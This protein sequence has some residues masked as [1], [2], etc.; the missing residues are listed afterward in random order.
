MTFRKEAALLL[1]YV[2][3]IY[4]CTYKGK[5]HLEETSYDTKKYVWS[6]AI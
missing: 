6:T 2:Y 3:F 1:K 5:H 4:L